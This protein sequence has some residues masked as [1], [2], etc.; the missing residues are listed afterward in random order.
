MVPKPEA[1]GQEV[2]PLEGPDDELFVK[3]A[4]PGDVLAHLARIVLAEETLDSLLSKVI[5]LTV[6]VIPAADEVSLTL[7]R[8]GRPETAPIRARSQC[9]R[10]SA[11]TGSTQRPCLVAARGGEALQVADVRSEQRWLRPQAVEIGVLSS[12]SI[13]LPI[14]RTSSA[15]STSTPA[16]RTRS[17]TTTSGPV[18]R[19]PPTPPSP[20]PMPARSPVRQNH[21]APPDSHMSRAT[22]KQAKGIV[23][24][25]RHHPRLSVRDAR[26]AS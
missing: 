12:L 2:D 20:S 14:S 1:Y 21:G 23:G 19:S 24:H 16:R 22:I 9:R 7:V 13:P 11:N 4:L 5:A 10:T 26:A 3:E 25:R 8:R 17:T 15:P 18:R 6:Q